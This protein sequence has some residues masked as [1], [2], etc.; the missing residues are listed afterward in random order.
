MSAPVTLFSG[1]VFIYFDFL[2][3]NLN[4]SSAVEKP[5]ELTILFFLFRTRSIRNHTRLYLLLGFS[6]VCGIQFWCAMCLFQRIDYAIHLFGAKICV[7]FC[8]LFQTAA[9]SFAV[10]S[11][12]FFRLY[13]KLWTNVSRLQD[14][15]LGTCIGLVSTESIHLK[16]QFKLQF[17]QFSDGRPFPLTPNLGPS[18]NIIIASKNLN[19]ESRMAYHVVLRAMNA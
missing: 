19:I 12:F 16:F 4:W 13:C 8:C 18:K 7:F 11:V 14:Q 15:P 9:G 2:F 17:L 1:F 6:W 10:F 3:Y 5:Y